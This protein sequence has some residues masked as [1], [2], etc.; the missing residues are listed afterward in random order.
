MVT[1]DDGT[2]SD[3]DQVPT[4]ISSDSWNNRVGTI[5]LECSGVWNTG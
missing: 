4:V 1:P 2:G 5:K 3:V